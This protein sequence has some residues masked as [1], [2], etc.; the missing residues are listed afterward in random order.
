MHHTV[1]KVHATKVVW[2]REVKKE[3]WWWKNGT[4]GQIRGGMGERSKRHGGRG[5]GEKREIRER[6]KRMSET[7]RERQDRERE[8]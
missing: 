2:E 3:S 8:V 7:T 6:E 4:D 5:R 1:T